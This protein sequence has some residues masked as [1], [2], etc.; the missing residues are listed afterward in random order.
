MEVGAQYPNITTFRTLNHYALTTDFE[1][2]VE[3]SDPTRLTT[4]C[5]KKDCSW[6][7]HA[8]VVVDDVT[9]MVKTLQHKYSCSGVN[10]CGNKHATKGWIADRIIS[11]L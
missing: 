5:A 9:F 2:F 11:D 1:F 10:K 8:Y 7:I 6:R 4:R 3:K